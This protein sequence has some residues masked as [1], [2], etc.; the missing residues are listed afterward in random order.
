MVRLVDENDPTFATG[1]LGDEIELELG[2]F[3]L[4]FH[5]HL[6]ALSGDIPWL[7]TSTLS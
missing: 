3:G 1:M 2:F 5:F 4:I 7:Q 6:D